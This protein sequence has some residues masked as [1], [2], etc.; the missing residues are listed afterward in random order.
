MAHVTNRCAEPLQVQLSAVLYDTQANQPVA[1]T[2]GTTFMASPGQTQAVRLTLEPP[3]RPRLMF[4]GMAPALPTPEPAPPRIVRSD[5]ARPMLNAAPVPPEQP[6]RPAG[7]PALPPELEEFRQR[8]ARQ[9]ATVPP[10]CVDV[11]GAGCL[12]VDP[13]LLQ[14]VEV[15][16]GVE[17]GRSLLSTAAD[18]GVSILRGPLF[19]VLG[20]YSALTRTVRVSSSLD[21]QSD[22]E[23]ATVVA[24]ELQHAADHSAGKLL[25]ERGSISCL[26]HEQDAFSRE[27]EVWNTLWQGNLPEPRDRI[28]RDLNQ[29]VKD[30]NDPQAQQRT[31][32]HLYADD[33]VR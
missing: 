10:V 3:P 8:M 27:A 16:A 28:Q 31:L 7:A 32:A 2:L 9:E 29:S 33:C 25:S 13:R 11:G 15:L 4:E 5:W 14:T 24:H 18:F 19:G 22:W 6:P 23:R 21:D 30:A 12:R 1:T 26:E 20:Q 17:S